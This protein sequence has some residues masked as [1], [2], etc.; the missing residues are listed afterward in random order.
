M[1]RQETNCVS[2]ASNEQICAAFGGA[3]QFVP[4]PRD[5][6][7][8]DQLITIAP[9]TSIPHY[10][11]RWRD[12]RQLPC[13]LGFFPTPLGM[14]SSFSELVSR[15][16]QAIEIRRLRALRRVHRVPAGGRTARTASRDRPSVAAD[17][18]A[19]AE[20][21]SRC[22]R[23]VSSPGTAIAAATPGG[24]RCPHW[25]QPDPDRGGLTAPEGR[26]AGDTRCAARRVAMRPFGYLLTRQ[27][28]RWSRPE[29]GGHL[30]TSVFVDDLC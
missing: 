3:C 26:V 1:R 7:V 6:A 30:A 27:L 21:R 14:A 22:I 16:N 5:R 23:R 19:S 2:S 13:R 11:W 25:R 12:V 28:D 18:Q 29:I 17:N 20:S 4:G 24:A 10:A 8:G 15:S 9:K